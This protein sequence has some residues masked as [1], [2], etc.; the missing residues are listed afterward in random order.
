[1]HSLIDVHI[2]LSPAPHSVFTV[3]CPVLDLQKAFDRLLCRS[4]SFGF[5]GVREES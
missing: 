2:A 3:L 5:L 1:M 4:F